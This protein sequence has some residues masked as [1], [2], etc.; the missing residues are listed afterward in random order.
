MNSSLALAIAM[1][2]MGSV[3]AYLGPASKSF[4]AKAPQSEADK[5]EALAR[6]EEK[7]Q[8]KILARKG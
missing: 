7:R 1:L 2:H 5:L 3:P 8:R 4:R 6:A